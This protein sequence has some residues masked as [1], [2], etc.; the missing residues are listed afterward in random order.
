MARPVADPLTRGA[1]LGGLRLVSVDGCEWA[2]PDNQ[3]NAAEFGY[4]GGGAGGAFPQA[5][6]VG[7]VECGSRA[8]WAA[9]IGAVRGA[10]SG[11]QSLAR[12]L[13]P[14]LEP[15]MLLLADRNFY[16]FGDWCA[17]TGTGAELLWRMD[18]DLRL[19]SCRHCRTAPTCRSCST[20]RSGGRPRTPAAGCG[21]R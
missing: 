16:S 10:G 21:R 9:R 3:A 19:P 11:E 17:A 13:Y 8:F 18:S 2:V 5:R 14:L 6:L 4:P 15:D 20:A 1:W 7:L 12:E